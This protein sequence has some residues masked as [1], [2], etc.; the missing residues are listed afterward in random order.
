MSTWVIGGDWQ[1]DWSNQYDDLPEMGQWDDPRR[2]PS[3]GD[4]DYDPTPKIIVK[5]QPRPDYPSPGVYETTPI[6]DYSSDP[7][8]HPV[9]GGSTKNLISWPWETADGEGI[10][11][12]WGNLFG[13]QQNS[14]TG[15]LSTLFQNPLMLILLILSMRR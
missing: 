7:R 9:F 3:P 6:G 10:N 4:D 8:V 12:N 14:L 5:T 11:F 13:T 2:T 15:N 1:D